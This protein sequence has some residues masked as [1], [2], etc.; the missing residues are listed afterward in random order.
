MTGV[1]STVGL[2]GRLSVSRVPDASS[3]DAMVLVDTGVTV[4]HAPGD[5]HR[6]DKLPSVYQYFE[7][8]IIDMVSADCAN[9]WQS[10]Q[11]R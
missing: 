9:V 5:D 1:L 8:L 11:F 7:Q 3:A 10:P 6:N 4:G 2:A